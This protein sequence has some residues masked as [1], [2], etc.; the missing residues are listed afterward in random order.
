MGCLS[1]GHTGGIAALVALHEKHP[2]LVERELIAHGMRWRDVG[3]PSCTWRDVF[4]L[5]AAAPP[6]SP[7]HIAIHG[8]EASWGPTEHLLANIAD[9][10]AMLRYERAGRKGRKPKLTPRPGKRDNQ[11]FGKARPLSQTRARLE[12]RTGRPFVPGAPT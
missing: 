9:Q 7:V 1:L 11:H 6:Q 12:R 10:I 8:E 4:A 2:L 3:S 5:F